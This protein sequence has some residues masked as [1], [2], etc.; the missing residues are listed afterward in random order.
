MSG[1]TVLVVEDD[2]PFREAIAVPLRAAG[3]LVE[4]CGDGEE[5]LARVRTIR[6]DLL[7]T[8]WEM[9]RMDGLTLCRLVRSIEELRFTHVIILSSRGDTSAKVAGLET[10]A[11]DY[12]VKPIDPGELVARV[13][14]G[15]RLQRALAELAAKNE[16]LERLALADPLT[17]LANRRGFDESLGREVA[18]AFR[19]CKP[20]SL[21]YLD[22]DHF[23]A[24]NDRFGHAAGDDVLGAFASLLARSSRRGDLAGRIGGEE[25]ALLLPH[26]PREQAVL[27]AERIRRTTERN[28]LGH[29]HPVAVTVSVGVATLAGV[30]GESGPAL[31]DRADAALYQAKAL[32]RNRV[33]V[34]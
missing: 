17:G 2:A 23:K 21:L 5:A 22:L 29:S 13:R 4:T 33:A 14:S 9:P 24:V 25:F 32:G 28:P 31:V 15:L 19:V 12:L 26:T 20:L 16:L 18:R 1:G 30:E 27:A 3:F 34:A 10:G 11:D 6:P 7:L 8:D